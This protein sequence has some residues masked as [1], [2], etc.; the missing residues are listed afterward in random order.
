MP[1]LIEAEHTCRILNKPQGHEL[2][3]VKIF[4]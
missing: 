1:E 3:A 2:Y 4:F